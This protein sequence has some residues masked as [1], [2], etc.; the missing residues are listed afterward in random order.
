MYFLRTELMNTIL[1]F[2]WTPRQ[3]VTPDTA[4]QNSRFPLQNS[5]RYIVIRYVSA[6]KPFLIHLEVT[7]DV[8]EYCLFIGINIDKKN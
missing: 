7:C 8:P 3:T 5:N 1:R 2:D 6:W 4:L